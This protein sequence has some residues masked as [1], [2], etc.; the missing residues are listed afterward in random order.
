[1]PA[2]ARPADSPYAPYAALLTRPEVRTALWRRAW[3][4]QRADAADLVS[5]CLEVLWRRRDDPNLPDSLKRMI[6]LALCVIDAK[7]VDRT[8]RRAVARRRLVDAARLVPRDPDDPPLG[9]ADRKNRTG[10]R[11]V[12]VTK[13]GRLRLG[14]QGDRK[15]GAAGSAH[16]P[17]SS[18][19]LASKRM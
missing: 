7:L 13:R 3:R 15:H 11:T 17:P 5:D 2:V 6:G 9:E 16:R 8:R 19:F 10:T 4:L 12:F 1:M 18:C 14:D